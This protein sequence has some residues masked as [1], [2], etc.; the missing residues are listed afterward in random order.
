LDTYRHEPLKKSNKLIKLSNTILLPHI[1]SASFDTRRRMS[2]IA[3][4]NLINVLEGVAPIY[5]VN[6]HVT[7]GNREKETTKGQYL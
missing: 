5:P 7:Y 2:R 1:G 4:Q 6:P 3:A